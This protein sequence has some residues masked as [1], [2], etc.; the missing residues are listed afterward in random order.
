MDK[1]TD[2][3]E[4]ARQYFDREAEDYDTSSDGK[5]VRSMYGEIVSRAAALPCESF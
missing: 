1:Q 4:R 2:V 3:S 5:F